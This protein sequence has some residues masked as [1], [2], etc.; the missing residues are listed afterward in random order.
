M[1]A[2]SSKRYLSVR[3]TEVRVVS[4]VSHLVARLGIFREH[5][6]QTVTKTH[7]VETAE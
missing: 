2:F 3:I 6:Q 4:T 7:R 5:T 1:N